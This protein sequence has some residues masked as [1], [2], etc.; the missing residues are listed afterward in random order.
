M[1]DPVED[2]MSK[3]PT[4]TDPELEAAFVRDGYVVVPFLDRDEV[5]DLRSAY[6]DDLGVAPG[7]PRKACIST[8][9]TYDADYKAGVDAHVRRVFTPHLDEVFVDQRALPANYLTKWPGGMSGFGLHHDLTLVDEDQFRSCEVW[10][11]LTDTN[12]ENGQLWVVPGSHEWVPTMRGVH[13]FPT[14]FQHVEKRI[15]ERH[16]IPMPIKAGE[17]IVFNHATLHFSYPN[18]SETPRLVAIMDLIPDEAQHIH[19]FG[20]GEGHAE[21]YAIEDSFWVE[22]NPFTLTEPPAGAPS[23]GTVDFETTFLT[24][25]MLDELVAEGRAV[26]RE[27]E[28]RGALNPAKAWC[29]RCG[30]TEGVEG[31]PGRWSG[32]ITLLCDPCKAHQAEL[33]S[34]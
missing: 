18:K 21:A 7:D 22:Q 12:E 10:C 26:D 31:T 25:E 17:A 6:W 2:A 27:P 34:A 16:A 5:A 29:H 30:T 23:L 32:N 8:F 33:V 24:D 28:R 3:R 1:A 4:F 13:A 20:D 15:V 9:H 14:A 11:A 19:V